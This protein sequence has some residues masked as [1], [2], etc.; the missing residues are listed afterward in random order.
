M[1]AC[2]FALFSHTQNHITFNKMVSWEWIFIGSFSF[3]NLFKLSGNQWM[4]SFVRDFNGFWTEKKK[5]N[6]ICIGYWHTAQQVFSRFVFYLYLIFYDCSILIRI[7][8]IFGSAINSVVFRISHTTV[9]FFLFSS[10]SY[11]LSI[12]SPESKKKK[13][14]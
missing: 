7:L 6:E 4:D 14:V 11:V 13:N 3:F 9:D 10:N 5:R 2:S 1:I 8:Y 12:I